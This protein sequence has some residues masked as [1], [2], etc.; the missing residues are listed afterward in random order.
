MIFN[1]VPETFCLQ[2]KYLSA[3][4]FLSQIQARGNF[5]KI[6]ANDKLGRIKEKIMITFFIIFN[7]IHHDK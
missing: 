1:W 4:M 5:A 7:C 3:F 2:S 6:S